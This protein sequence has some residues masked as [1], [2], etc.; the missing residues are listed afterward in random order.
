MPQRSYCIIDC[1]SQLSCISKWKAYQGCFRHGS[2][3]CLWHYTHY[4]RSVMSQYATWR[5]Y[6]VSEIYIPV[7]CLF[8]FEG[9]TSFGMSVFNL[10]NAI[11][12]SGIL[13]LSYAMSNTGIVL[14]LWVPQIY[15]LR[16][17][18]YDWRWYTHPPTHTHVLCHPITTDSRQTDTQGQYYT[19][20]G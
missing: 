9:K 16:Y 18:E 10:S 13:G 6:W 17:R 4:M 11:M 12:G 1:H 3:T 8:Q 20:P 5:H 19:T 2:I 14:F 7:F 15:S